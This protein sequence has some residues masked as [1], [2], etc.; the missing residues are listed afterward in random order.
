MKSRPWNRFLAFLALAILIPACHDG[1]GGGNAPPP[2]G[3]GGSASTFKAAKLSGSQEVPPVITSGTGDATAVF[4]AT[5]TSIQVTVNFSGL[6]NLTAAH[7]HVGEIGEDGPI[8]FPLAS[9]SFTSPLV[10]TLTSAAFTPQPAAGITTFSQ[11]VS[12]IQEGRTYVNL[13]TAAFEDGEIRGQIGPVTL[14]AE[15]DG[16]QEVPPILTTAA[17]SMTVF[18]NNDQSTLTFTLDYSNLQN[19]NAA[20]IHVAPVGVDGPIIFPLANA[21][22]ASPLSGTLTEAG[23][24]PQPGAGIN[25]FADAVNAMI[26]GLTYVNVHTTT[27]PDGEIR[28][29]IQGPQV[30]PPPPPTKTGR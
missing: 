24:T 10:V 20:H 28:G 11:A 8:I 2:P 22:F 17:G 15:L 26:S 12:A 27:N 7:I 6:T 1:D 5:L 18:L 4:D 25:T 9:G 16:L 14:T 3:G 29:Q 30:P 21:S 13:H 23:L 19:I